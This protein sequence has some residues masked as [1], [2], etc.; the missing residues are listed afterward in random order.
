MREASAKRR[1]TRP[2]EVA[3]A[4]FAPP[5]HTRR[6]APWQQEQ[7]VSAALSQK[8]KNTEGVRAK[9]LLLLPGALTALPW[10]ALPSCRPGLPLV[11]VLASAGARAPCIDIPVDN[12]RTT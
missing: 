11:L 12:G 5:T 7:R 4:A 8:R 6:P 3:H 2:G 10:V 9:P 1:D